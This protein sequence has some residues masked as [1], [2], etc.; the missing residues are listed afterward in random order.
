MEVAFFHRAVPE[1]RN[2]DPAIGSQLRRQTRSHRKRNRGGDERHRAEQPNV[3]CKKVHRPATS[4]GAAGAF[5]E[6]FR[7][8][9][10]QIPAFGQV[11]AV[12]AVSA[13]DIVLFLERRTD[14]GRD[15]FLPNAEMT[16]S[17]D[18]ASRDE[19]GDALLNEAN[20]Q[21][22]PIHPTQLGHSDAV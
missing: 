15:G 7:H 5:P 16:R 20:P 3:G 18:V 14:P 8:H 12:R 4:S 1:E 21:H 6:D 17:L 9:G 13:P 11:M 22:R 10:L 19:V 2:R